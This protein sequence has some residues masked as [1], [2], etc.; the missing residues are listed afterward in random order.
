[1]AWRPEVEWASPGSDPS[2]DVSLAFVEAFY[3][4]MPANY[5]VLFDPRSMRRHAGV[6]FRRGGRA[7][8]AEVWKPLTDASAALCVVATD[9]P[10]LLSAIAAALVSHRLDVITALVF[11]RTLPDGEVEAVDFLWVRRASP[12][13]RA[14]IGAEEVVSIGEVLN[15]ILS[16]NISAEE[17]AQRSVAL[18]DAVDARVIVRVEGGDGDAAAV[19]VVE[20]ADRPGVLLTIALEVFQQ[21]AQIVRSLVRT[22]DGRAYNRF[23]LVEFSGAGLSLERREQIRSAVFA[24]LTLTRP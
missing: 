2:S 21:G 3:A 10:G 7:A 9:R 13:D 8:H 18:P 12:E 11:S 1:M 19:L 5:R 4:S 6:A 23:D 16:G 20:A 22:A 15:A 24:A 17:I 14:D